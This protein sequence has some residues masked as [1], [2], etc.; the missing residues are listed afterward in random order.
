MKGDHRSMV[1][2]FDILQLFGQPIYKLDTPT[3]REF[4]AK[5]KSACKTYIEAKYT[6]LT[7][8]KFEENLQ[9]CKNNWTAEKLEKLDNEFQ[10]A[11]RNGAKKCKK[12]PNSHFLFSIAEMRKKQNLL[13]LIQTQRKTGRDMDASIAHSLSTGHQFQIPETDQ[14]I[15]LEIKRL[16]RAIRIMSKKASTYREDHLKRQ[17]TTLQQ[18]NQRQKANEI[19]NVLYTEQMKKIY[20]KIR[21][22][23][24]VQKGGLT[25]LQVP[26]DPA[27][28]DYKKCQNWVTLELP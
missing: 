16:Q 19:K 5:D 10:R 20:N 13:R 6:Y 28:Q 3:A 24:G 26:A 18:D 4:S 21:K 2:D 14:S 25:K 12:K 7:Q 22:C 15:N 11:G 17:I 1:I 27:E 23:R 8:H 9:C